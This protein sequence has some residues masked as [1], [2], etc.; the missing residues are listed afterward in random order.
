MEITK[1]TYTVATL[2]APLTYIGRHAIP[3]NEHER[4]IFH[5]LFPQALAVFISCLVHCDRSPT[6]KRATAARVRSKL[7]DIIFWLDFCSAYATKTKDDTLPPRHPIAGLDDASLESEVMSCP[8]TIKILLRCWS[9]RN[10]DEDAPFP[11]MNDH[12]H[13]CNI[14]GLLRRFL[15][16]KD[17]R[18]VL[19]DAILSSQRSI[20]TF[21]DALVARIS[22]I[23]VLEERNVD[24]LVLAHRYSFLLVTCVEL[25]ST[26]AIYRGMRRRGFLRHGVRASRFLHANF[27]VSQSFGDDARLVLLSHQPGANPVKGMKEVIEAGMVPLLM[28][29]FKHP[30]AL[31]S[32]KDECESVFLAWRAST[33]HFET[34]EVL[35]EALRKLPK[36]LTP[37]ASAWKDEGPLPFRTWDNWY[38]VLQARFGFS[39]SAYYLC[40]NDTHYALNDRE[41]VKPMF[42][43]GCRSVMYCSVTCQRADWSTRHREECK[44]MHNSY[45]ERK[46]NGIRFSQ[47]AR[48]QTVALFQRLF[49]I[50][51]DVLD[52]D[53]GEQFPDRL[54]TTNDLI[55]LLD[56]TGEYWT[57]TMV[58][59]RIVEYLET[60]RRQ[61][62]PECP[63]LEDRASGIIRGFRENGDPEAR[64]VDVIVS[65]S[66]M[67]RVSLLVEALP[68]G[69]NRGG[70]R[71]WDVVRSMWQV[72]R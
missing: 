43:A 10:G 66:P 54:T 28:E 68:V 71:K 9:F 32:H 20:D 51:A 38:S 6:H 60:K 59:F 48:G 3:R 49:A 16:G 12:G 21:C 18:T 40:D 64:L 69:P 35:L 30:E 61:T 57:M 36:E 15:L 50:Y 34:F 41:R 67:H 42:C 52:K 8:T 47:H 62:V 2:D 37:T 33:F 25:V 56:F 39:D 14:T 23:P 65:W 17:S 44:V 13:N 31:E 19:L 45:L 46:R 55:T 26:Q 63:A 27:P 24:K 1:D 22:Q 29:A 5:D 4:I 11:P 70:K 58:S 72:E 53:R 7:D